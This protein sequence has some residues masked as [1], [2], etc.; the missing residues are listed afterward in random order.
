[1][2]MTALAS[3]RKC[4]QGHVLFPLGHP[5]ARALHSV[6]K[7]SYDFVAIFAG[8]RWQRNFERLDLQLYSGAP[9]FCFFYTY[10][11]VFATRKKRPAL[12]LERESS[13]HGINTDLAARLLKRHKSRQDY[14]PSY[15]PR[16]LS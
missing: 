11:Y 5:P 12:V 7:C 1:M 2:G 9:G 16:S 3:Q 6:Y 4:C 8:W 14:T 10:V 13:N 15:S